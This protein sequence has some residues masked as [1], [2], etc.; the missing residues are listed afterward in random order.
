MI[1]GG[2][3]HTLPVADGDRP[4]RD[5]KTNIAIIAD[6]DHMP[7]IRQPDKVAHRILNFF[8]PASPR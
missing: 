2:E 4:A 3:D 7:Y 8:Q 6:A 1:W 5:L